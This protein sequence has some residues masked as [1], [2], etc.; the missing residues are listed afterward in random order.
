MRDA[1]SG[2]GYEA[3]ILPYPTRGASQPF[4]TA[5]LQASAEWNADLA[6]RTGRPPRGLGGAPFRARGIAVGQKIMAALVIGCL[7]SI[8]GIGPRQSEKGSVSTVAQGLIWQCRGGR[9][10]RAD[11]CEPAEVKLIH[12]LQL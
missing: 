9:T 5:G 4:G 10:S 1:D 12:F 6:I 8:L 11:N 7:V 2:A 3:S